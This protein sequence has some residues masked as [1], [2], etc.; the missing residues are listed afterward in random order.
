M[1][2]RS[3]AVLAV[4]LLMTLALVGPTFALPVSYVDQGSPAQTASI[5]VLEYSGSIYSGGVYTGPY[6]L[7]VDGLLSYWMCF[8]A[9]VTV[10]QSWN[11]LEMDTATAATYIGADK[12]NMIAYLANQWNGSAPNN[13]SN[14]DINLAMWE[15]MA[16][17]SGISQNGFD[18][19]G[20]NASAD[21]FITT[22]DVDPVTNKLKDAFAALGQLGNGQFYQAE[23]L[24]P[25]SSDGKLSTISQPFVQPVPEPATLLLLGS[26]LL[27]LGAWR[28]RNRGSAA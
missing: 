22:T 9:S 21:K 18:N 28:R 6:R 15:I 5:T 11:A 16:D 4:S 12:A 3:F 23:F 24:L 19:S 14:L 20:L 17:Y 10:A 13:Q 27:G 25:V 8:D 1:K 7:Q 2:G 26:G